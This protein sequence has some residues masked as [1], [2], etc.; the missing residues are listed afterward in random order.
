MNEAQSALL[1]ARQLMR[2][3]NLEDAER[4]ENQKIY[5]LALHEYKSYT[6]ELMTITYIVKQV[7][8]VYVVLNHGYP[9]NTISAHGTKTEVEIAEYLFSYLKRELDYQYQQMRRN[10]D[11]YG[12]GKTS[13]YNGMLSEMQKRFS[14]Q[15]DTS[16]WGLV[17]YSKENEKL[18]KD[19]IYSDVKLRSKI[20]YTRVSN[21][22]AYNSGKETGKSL[23]IHNGLSNGSSQSGKYLG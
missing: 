15:E 23:R 20:S 11:F 14:K 6:A 12:R 2:E 13:F 19:L 4:K 10:G 5:R 16:G 7:S 22:R 9:L 1:K 21:S 3:Y 18:A 17:E 8:N